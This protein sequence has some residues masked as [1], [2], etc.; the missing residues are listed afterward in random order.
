MNELGNYIRMHRMRAGLSQ[1][2]LGKLLGYGDEGQVP[3]HE[4]SHS[5]PTFMIAI[6]YEVIFKVPAK[7][8][9]AGVHESIADAIE[10][11]LAELEE[12]LRKR[13]E[14]GTA[15]ETTARKLQW[16]QERRRTPSTQ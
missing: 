10:D 16:L 13:V 9:F 11:R 12:S 2:E 3:R 14:K 7:E 8:M 1:C 5:L 15:A 4:K 6:S